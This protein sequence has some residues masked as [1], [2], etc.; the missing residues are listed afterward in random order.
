MANLYP[1]K[2]NIKIE[3]NN[4]KSRKPPLNSLYF[5][6]EQFNFIQNLKIRIL[7]F[8]LNKRFDQN[9]SKIINTLEIVR[10]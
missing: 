3:F 4:N 6:Y 10:E 1:F 5:D 7:Q 2:T 9:M 8:R